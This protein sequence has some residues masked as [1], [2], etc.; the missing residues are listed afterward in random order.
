M[1]KSDEELRPPVDLPDELLER[2]DSLENTELK[3]V[4][5]YVEKRIE[6][7]RTPFEEEIQATASGKI[8]DI[9][10]HGG[11]AL[12]RMHPPDPES[13][14]VDTDRVSV[15]HVKREPHPDGSESV[16]WERIGDMK[17]E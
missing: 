12:V 16:H 7:L 9:E 17:D 8:L 2:I 14:D 11:Y 10:K 5:S 1:T 15:Y 4:Q 6:S 13:S 3:A